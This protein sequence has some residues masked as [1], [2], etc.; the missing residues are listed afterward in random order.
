MPAVCLKIMTISLISYL[1]SLSHEF[2]IIAL[3][4]TWLI[5]S[6]EMLYDLPLYKA[7]HRYRTQGAGGGVS[8]YVHNS[9]QFC[10]REDLAL[11]LRSIDAE[12]LFTE[13]TSCSLFG[14]R[15]VIVGCVYRPPDTD[16]GGFNDVLAST[17]AMIN[18]ERQL[19]FLSSYL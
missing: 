15:N 1:S 10:V 6:I 8:I 16:I 2:S 17:L 9:L 12:A 7:V 19:C 3:S 13:I 4:E 14:G 18:L 5:D 11:A